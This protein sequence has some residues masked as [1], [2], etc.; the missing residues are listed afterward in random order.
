ELARRH[1]VLRTLWTHQ[2]AASTPVAPQALPDFLACTRAR[3]SSSLESAAEKP[4]P[5]FQLHVV[6]GPK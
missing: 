6:E 4:Q 1:I 3:R 5:R 2:Q